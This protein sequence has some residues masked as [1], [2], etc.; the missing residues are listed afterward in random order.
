MSVPTERR[1][2]GGGGQSLISD[3]SAIRR[4]RGMS[5][6]SGVLKKNP[7]VTALG[8]HQ[9]RTTYARHHETTCQL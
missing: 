4:E 8:A 1:S 2:P 7:I 9:L 5:E 3:G 6:A